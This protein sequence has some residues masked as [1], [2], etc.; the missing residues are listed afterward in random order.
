MLLLRSGSWAGLLRARER[1]GPEGTS[2]ARTLPSRVFTRVTKTQ[3]FT[4]IELMIVV[5]IVGVLAAIAIP[6]FLKFQMRSKASEGRLNLAAIRTAQEA[7]FSEIGTYLAWP[8]SPAA[9]VTSQKRAWTICPNV[10]PQ[11]GDP[12]YCFI[13]WAPEGDVYY[14]YIVATDTPP[15][16]SQFFAVGESD[17]DGDGNLNLWGYQKPDASGQFTIGATQGCTTVLNIEQSATSGANVA[18]TQQV[19]PCNS[20][21]FG[22]TV[23]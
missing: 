16:S 10:P 13:G 6:N 7:Y 1:A 20:P 4:L 12:G 18:M 19:G 8:L 2:L 11:A 22:I 23:F 9:A 15:P 3:G 17:I 5:A 21:L 14:S